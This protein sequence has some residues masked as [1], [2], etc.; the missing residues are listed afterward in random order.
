MYSKINKNNLLFILVFFLSIIKTYSQDKSEQCTMVNVFLSGELP[1]TSGEYELVFEDNFDGDVLD[2]NKWDPFT[3]VARDEEF[4]HVK[5]WYLPENLVVNNGTLKITSKRLE[6]PYVGTWYDWST[7]PPTQLTSSFDYTSGELRSKQKF[8]L[9]KYEIRC[10]LP[11]GKGFFPAF[12]AYSGPRWNELDIFDNLEGNEKFS[13]GPGYDYYNDGDAEGCRWGTTNIPD[14]SQWHTFTC[15]YDSDKIVWK[16]DDVVYRTLYR[17]ST[18]LGQDVGCGSSLAATYYNKIIAFPVEEMHII[19][20]LAIRSGASAP[21]ASTVFPAYYEVD[22]MRFYAKNGCDNCLDNQAYENT[23]SLPETTRTKNAI[24]AGNSVTVQNGQTVKFKAGNSVELQPGF[25][26][27]NGSSFLAQIENCNILNFEEMP[28]SFIG[29]NA[30]DGYIV[31]KTINP[32]YTIEATGI[33]YYSASVYNLLG[34]LVHSSC[35]IPGSNHIQTWNASNAAVGWYT[36]KLN[37]LNCTDAVNKEYN[38]Y[39]TNSSDKTTDTLFSHLDSMLLVSEDNNIETSNIIMDDNL[40]LYPNPV[41]N[42]VN[43]FYSTRFG[44]KSLIII[45]DMNGQE[46]LKLPITSS[47]GANRETI[48]VSYLPDGVYILSLLSENEKIENK[49]IVSR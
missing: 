17:Y 26:V 27:N 2:L 1:C 42:K 49:F 43:V 16:I 4:S 48:D 32:I 37:M 9:G 7:N 11:N 3:G 23:N 36:F 46:I 19:M 29:S 34:Q 6:T 14:L 18:L 24:S 12:W 35:G 20:N 40:V 38:L 45:T 13:C 31:N 8:L 15:E 28:I 33:T 21:N 5:V 25:K 44:C 30:I 41:S 10:R 22:Y 47:M 39:V